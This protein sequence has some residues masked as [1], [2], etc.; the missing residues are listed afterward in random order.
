MGGEGEGPSDF[1]GSEILA[2]SDFFGSMK[3][4]GIF[5]G[6]KKKKKKKKKEGFFWIA[7][8]LLRDFFGYTKKDVIFLGRQILKL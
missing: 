6:R 4:A 5:L 1:F 2:Q 7:E 8:K 3:Y